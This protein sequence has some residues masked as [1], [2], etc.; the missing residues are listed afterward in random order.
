MVLSL[1]L[2]SE[3]PGGLIKTLDADCTLRVSDPG[4]LE[5]LRICISKFEGEAAAASG[6]RDHTKVVPRLNGATFKE[7][8]LKI[9]IPG[10]HSRKSKFKHLI[11]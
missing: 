7:S 6:T 9:Q 10:P 1:L 5:W 11:I 8:C 4:G 2:G 3:L